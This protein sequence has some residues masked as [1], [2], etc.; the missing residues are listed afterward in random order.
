MKASESDKTEERE[1]NPPG[2]QD[3]LHKRIPR[4][5]PAENED[6]KPAVSYGPMAPLLPCGASATGLEKLGVSRGGG[7]GETGQ[8][9]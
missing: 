3:P 6:E 9:S 8:V 4:D 2:R 5:C 1:R 7:L